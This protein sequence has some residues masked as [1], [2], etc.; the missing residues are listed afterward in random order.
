MLKNG[1]SFLYDQQG[2]G[3]GGGP[4][5]WVGINGKGYPF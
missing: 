1:R 4:R 2:D 3:Q 5:Q